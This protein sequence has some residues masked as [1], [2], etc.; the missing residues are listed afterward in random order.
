MG[1]HRPVPCGS[2]L[3]MSLLILAAL[4][5]QASDTV[6]LRPGLVITRSAVVRP[7]SYALAPAGTDSVVIRVRGDG[8]VLD[9]QGATLRGLPEGADPDRASG[10]GVLV[11]GG[12]GVT[13]RRARIHGYKIGVL[14]RGARGFHLLDN[15]LSRNWRPR[16]WSGLGHESLLDW[17]YFH[18]NEHEEWLR[19]G[20]GAY[21]VDVD[22]GVVRGNRATNGMNALLLVRSHRL[23]I[24]NN[25]FSY[26]SGLGIGLYRATHN[27]IMHNRLDYCVRGYVHGV[28]RRGQD[29]AALLLYEQSTDNVVAYNSMTHSGDGIFL[30]AGQSTMDTGAGGAND[31]LFF[32]NDVSFAVA[33][34]V[35]AT[36]SRNR[37]I[38]NLSEGSEYG[39]WGGYSFETV[40]RGNR[41]VR[42]VTGVAIEHGQD[43]RIESNVFEGGRTAIRL[44]ANPIEP[45]DWGYP[46]YRDT[47]S[48]DNVV[49]RNSFLDNRI[50]LRVNDTPTLQI[51]GNGFLRVD[52]V[53][54]RNGTVADLDRGAAIPA[55]PLPVRGWRP[56][57][58]D[59]EAPR[60]LSGAITPWRPA[61]Q[62]RGRET[63]LVDE[64]GPYDGSTPRL[65]PLTSDSAWSGGPLALEVVGPDGEW[66]VTY[67]EGVREISPRAGRTG[68]TIHV[69]P[70]TGSTSL[71]HLEL[72]HRVAGQSAPRNMRY[73]RFAAPASWRIKVFPWDSISDP[74]S[75]AA[76]TFRMVL[77]GAPVV[78]HREPLLD[79]MF[80]RSRWPGM[81]AE[82][83]AVVAEGK[84]D[85][86][87]GHY[88]IRTISDD[89]IRVWVDDRLVIDHWAPHESEVDRAGL[90]DGKH[91]LRVEYYQVGGWVELRVEIGKAR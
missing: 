69:T 26:L 48:R 61:N 79:W 36:F 38:G 70:A 63:I 75:K 43:N 80:Y 89:G 78:E 90:P 58:S 21:L 45:S 28:Y 25:D 23:T 29:S 18:Q 64:W 1:C 32:G 74:R 30:W 82:R 20:A 65:W 2:I 67:S 55:M 41:F 81:P 49:A 35:E 5:V 13:I 66:R 72:E 12:N 42:N 10:I 17:L 6:T 47:R 54:V 52:T 9:F 83:F 88:E 39:I 31:N 22:G 15:D 37:I 59:P 73:E 91:R 57:L 84:V 62:P 11:E 51:D 19:Y 34:G 4:V 33:N 56:D 24:S 71:V 85:L 44:W 3:G 87:P 27:T 40:I 60:P 53:L 68:D 46:K 86:P 8:I 76:E 50:A 16:L 14:A 7:G 77:T